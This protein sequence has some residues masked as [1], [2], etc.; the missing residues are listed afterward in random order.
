MTPIH[1]SNDTNVVQLHG[2]KWQ[3]P[4][5]SLLTGTLPAPAFPCDVLG[6][7][8]A[9]WCEQN[10]DAAN[11][12]Y[13]YVAASLITAAAALIGNARTVTFGSWSQPATIWTVLVGSP[14]AK[15]SPAM[16]PLNRAV[17]ELVAELVGLNGPNS[18]NPQLRISDVTA[19]AAA[20]VAAFN[21]GGLLLQRDELSGWWEQIT[22]NGGEAMWLEAYDAGPYT[23]NR[24][25][26]P[27]VHI[28]RLNISV[29]GTAQPDPVRALL[30]A[31]TDRGFAARYLYIYPE[32]KTG[33]RRPTSVDQSLAMD[34]LRRLRDLAVNHGGWLTCPL[35]SE[36]EDAADAWL[37]VHDD[38]THQSDGPWQQWL[39]KQSGMLLR[40]ALVLEHLWWCMDAAGQPPDAVGQEAIRAAGE[41]IDSYAAPMAARSF[42]MAARPLVEQQAASLAR[43]LQRK[44]EPAFNAR[45]VRRGSFGPVGALAQAETMEKACAVLE[46][47]FL[48]RK[49]GVRAGKTKGRAPGT[50]EVNPALFAA[51]EAEVG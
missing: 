25:G 22:R 15:K 5:L 28:P 45:E 51:Q 26:K 32:A 36:A 17:G 23:V 4:D 14:S 9:Q 44:Q 10:A 1:Q 2:P 18:P 7:D 30:E 21:P 27:P 35:T 13:D 34:A 48:I 38:R 40:Y 3:T 29:L 33:F 46:A 39:G 43:V 12:P 16:A 8:W 20:E 47:A 24:K 19:Q 37:C 41:F 42:N 50:Y 31:K 11:A 49:V 6:A